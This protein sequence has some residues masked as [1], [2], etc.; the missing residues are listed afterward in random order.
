MKRRS[1]G[2]LVILTLIVA[3]GTI[4]QDVRFERSLGRTVDG[5]TMI[6]REVA[7]VQASLMELRAAQAAYVATGQNLDYW[8]TRAAELI[9]GIEQAVG[10]L[11]DRATDLA[12]KGHYETA[13]RLVGDLKRLD[14]R[15]RDNAKREQRF[16][17]SDLIFMDALEVN[18]R[19]TGS[20]DEARTAEAAAAAAARTRMGWLRLAVQ[21]LALGF[22]SVVMLF[23]AR[24]A[25]RGAEAS[26]MLAANA[27]RDITPSVTT[28]ALGLSL[29]VPAP[30]LADDV[31]PLDGLGPPAPA[32]PPPPPPVTA[33]VVNLTEAAELCVDLARVMDTRDLPALLGR[34]ARVLDAKGVVLWIADESGSLLVPTL[35]HGYPDKTIARLGSLSADGENV[36]SAAFRSLRPQTVTSPTPKGNGAIAVPLITASGCLG[37]L[38]A[39][40]RQSKPSGER[41]AIARVIAAQLAALVTPVEAAEI[42]PA[43]EAN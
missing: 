4:V 24:A 19:L 3:L 29:A 36:T 12:A 11:R 18:R 15:A 10:S 31:P 42:R 8:A 23:Y 17:A 40:I 35:S 21:G 13:A 34:A 33:T 27:P 5:A 9:A 14:E 32:A 38:A 2:P 25:S 7:A 37:V 28:T 20:L 1:A 39:E 43:A 16:V 22:L 26:E 6:D 30:A 41:T